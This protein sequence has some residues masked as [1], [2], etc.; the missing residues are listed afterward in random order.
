MTGPETGSPPSGPGRLSPFAWIDA[1]RARSRAAAT[2]SAIAGERGTS[3]AALTDRQRIDNYWQ[4][5]GAQ[6]LT[7]RQLRRAQHK[8]NRALRSS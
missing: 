7:P 1:L 5:N 3:P 2:A 6:R 4:Q 8:A